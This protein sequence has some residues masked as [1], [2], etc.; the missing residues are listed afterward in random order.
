MFMLLLH[1]RWKWRDGRGFTLIEL[2][3]VIA[4]IAILIGLLLP[5]VQKVREAAGRAKCSNNLKQL[6]LACVHY[7]DA[8]GRGILPPGGSN[9]TESGNWLVFTLPYMEQTALYS[10][11]VKANNGAP[12]DTTPNSIGIAEAAGVLKAGS[13]GTKLPYGRC[14][15][16]DWDQTAAVVNYVG[17]LG[18]QCAPG[19]Y[20]GVAGDP[21]DPYLGNCNMPQWGW[22]TSPAHGN[23]TNPQ[24][25]RGLFNRLGAQMAYTAA[26][27][28]GTSNTIMIGEALPGVHDHLRNNRWYGYNDGNAHCT[29]IMPMNVI[30]PEQVDLTDAVCLR[31]VNNWDIVWG[32]S[33]RHTGG[34]NF[35]FADGSVHFLSNSISTELYNKLGC[36]NDGQAQPPN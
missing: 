10:Q 33:S 9:W 3:V 28:D 24:N 8:S 6:S 2:L 27:P 30:T 4:I 17:S 14:P 25:I 34:C 19:P 16:D 23:D 36:R 13:G 31:A 7:V 22:V 5:A 32:F 20:G 26:I 18:P 1:R 15:S 35:A 11:I 21:C 12:I 29:T